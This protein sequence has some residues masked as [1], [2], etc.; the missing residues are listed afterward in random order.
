MAFGGAILGTLIQTIK[1]KY[2]PNVLPVSIFFSSTMLLPL[3]VLVLT[4]DSYHYLQLAQ[5]A[6]YCLV[7]L[8]SV[9]YSEGII[10]KFLQKIVQ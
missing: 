9:K 2:Y 1:D 4:V 3:V 7:L 6:A 8:L 5:L 10:E